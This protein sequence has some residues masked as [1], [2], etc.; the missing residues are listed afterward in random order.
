MSKPSMPR[1]TKDSR[2]NSS[3]Y[4]SS[5]L[6]FG[7]PGWMSQ[8]IAPSVVMGFSVTPVVR[9]RFLRCQTQPPPPT[10]SRKG[11]G[12][13]WVWYNT[14]PPLAG[15]GWGR[16]MRRATHP[17]NP[18]RRSA[19]CQSVA[20]ASSA[21]LA[22]FCPSQHRRDA[23]AQRQFHRGP[24]RLARLQRRGLHRLGQHRRPADSCSCTSGFFSTDTRGGALPR[25]TER[26]STPCCTR[27]G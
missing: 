21:S 9:A 1:A 6:M 10:P 22:F 13:R 15:G 18:A 4:G 7:T 25:T 23:A 19:R 5:A 16:G 27:T 8:S 14:P 26:A 2:Q 24:D 17:F 3:M 12:S 20:T 11:R